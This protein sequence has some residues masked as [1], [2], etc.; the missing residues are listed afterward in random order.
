M[1]PVPWSWEPLPLV[2]FL[3]DSC[4][5]GA[6]SLPDGLCPVLREPLSSLGSQARG[7]GRPDTPCLVL[8][9]PRGGSGI[10]AG[11]G[12]GLRRTPSSPSLL[13]PQPHP[14]GS[15]AE[16]G[17]DP[18]QVAWPLCLSPFCL[19]RG[20]HGLQVGCQASLGDS[21]RTG[22]PP[23]PPSPRAPALGSAGAAAGGLRAELRKLRVGEPRGVAGG[24]AGGAGFRGVREWR[25][26][27][28]LLR[29][30]DWGRQ[31]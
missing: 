13:P 23:A 9:Q 15:W 30:R 6:R 8:S 19:T 4:Y 25:R 2:P 24:A 17:S 22:S 12:S 16:P 29:R 26:A 14:L 5:G 10:L 1:R 27:V 18:G 21:D 28:S 11:G 7:R 3:G 31:D 20:H